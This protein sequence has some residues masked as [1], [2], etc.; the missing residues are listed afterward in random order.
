MKAVISLGGKQ[1]TVIEGDEVVVNRMSVDEGK[2][3]I[4][5]DVLMI[6]DDDDT[7]IGKPFVKG[8]KVELSVD[9]HFKG[10][11]V[12]I[13]KFKKRNRYARKKGHRQPLTRLSVK[14]IDYKK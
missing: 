8:A 14:S 12:I 13:Y 3:H 11:K 2:T 9:E 6:N 4:C 5:E 10:D 7:V 1:H